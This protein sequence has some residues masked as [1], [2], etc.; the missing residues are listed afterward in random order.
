MDNSAASAAAVDPGMVGKSRWE[1]RE[2]LPPSK[3]RRR[4]FAQQSCVVVGQGF[5]C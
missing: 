4:R 5:A 1:I 3:S 2:T